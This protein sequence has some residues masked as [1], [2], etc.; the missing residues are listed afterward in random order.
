MPAKTPKNLK[1]LTHASDGQEMWVDASKIFS[2]WY[3]PAHK[4]TILMA[5]AG[6][7]ISVRESPEEV[8]QLCG[9]TKTKQKEKKNG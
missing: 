8:S 6:A 7:V 9:S 1:K 3:A 5:D 2:Y 4:A